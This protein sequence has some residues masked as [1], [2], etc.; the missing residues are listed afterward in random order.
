VNA[1]QN[2]T[3]NPEQAAKSNTENVS[4]VSTLDEGGVVGFGVGCVDCGCA[5]GGGVVVTL[6]VCDKRITKR[7]HN[8]NA[9]SERRTKSYG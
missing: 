8:Y 1:E 4:S 7:N 5:F 6:G 9:S 2:H 3:A